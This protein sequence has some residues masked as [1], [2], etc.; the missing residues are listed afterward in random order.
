MKNDFAKIIFHPPPPPVLPQAKRS[1]FFEAR[2]SCDFLASQIQRNFCILKI[3]SK[4]PLKDCP[5]A[6]TKIKGVPRRQPSA[7]H[8]QP[9]LTCQEVN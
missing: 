4:R 6:F 8:R 7:V 5:A 2:K 9:F 3:S 1:V